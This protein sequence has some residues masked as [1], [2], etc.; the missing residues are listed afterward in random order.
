MQQTRTKGVQDKAWLS[1]K[2]PS[3]GIV[4][5]IEIWSYDQMVYEKKN[6][7]N[8]IRLRKWDS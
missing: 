2:G 3:L 5:E 1:G 7:K 4:Q 6:K 8:R